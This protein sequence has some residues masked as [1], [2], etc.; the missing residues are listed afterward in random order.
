MDR[1]NFVVIMTEQHRGDCLGLAGHPVLL[2]PTM[3]EIGAGGVHFTSAYSTCPVCVPAR[4]TFLS[5]QSPSTHRI[6]HNSRSEW[7]G[8]TLPGVL[9]ANG[10]ETRWIGRSPHQAPR[11]KRYGFDHMLLHEDYFEWLAAREPEGSGGY[12]GTGVMHNDWTARP[13]HM[14][15]AF[16][17]T[18]WTVNMALEYLGKRDPSCPFF[19]VVSF[20]ASHPPLVPPAC[21]MDRYLRTGVPDPVIGEW[22]VPPDGAGHGFGPSPLSR[23]RLEGEAMRSARAAYYGLINHVDDQLHRLLNEVDGVLRKT[24]GNTVVLLCSDHG[25]M[26]GDHYLWRK[27]LPYEGSAH[28]PFLIRAP[29]RFRIKTGAV[30]DRPVCLEDIMPTVLDMAG[31]DIPESV[32]GAS[33]LPL[34]QGAETSWRPYVHVQ[35]DSN[36]AFHCLADGKEKFIR[37]TA[38]GREQFFDLVADPTECR[39]LIGSPTHADRIAWWRS[40]LEA[41]IAPK[42]ES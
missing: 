37:F 24:D 5:G 41:A 3:D 30:I 36:P 12:Y 1:P 7:D 13:W 40:E 2:T 33:V 34:M 17:H 9:S 15:E 38:D 4:R 11:R 32:D 42:P 6:L 39:N 22:A 23:V 35:E 18:N 20:I 16:H 10:Y 29:E 19:L 26:L 14:P 27:S 8:P 25:E 28:V 31:L 21:Y